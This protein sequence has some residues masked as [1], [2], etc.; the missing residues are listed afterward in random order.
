M[1]PAFFKPAK[2]AHFNNVINRAQSVFVNIGGA[3]AG[4]IFKFPDV[5]Q[6]RER[7]IQAIDVMQPGPLPDGSGDVV[8]N[9]GFYL[10]LV[11]AERTA[12][13]ENVPTQFFNS[14]AGQSNFK[15]FFPERVINWQQCE[16]LVRAAGPF[17]ADNFVGFTFFYV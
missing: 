4:S 8:T 11:D 6:L 12:F 14:V 3:V 9:A 5:P 7:K 17:A 15:Y 13:V 2:M 1:W 10:T 16:I